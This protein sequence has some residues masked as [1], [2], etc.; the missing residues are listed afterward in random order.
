M[1]KKGK[2]D[3]KISNVHHK[4]TLTMTLVINGGKTSNRNVC[5]GSP[6]ASLHRKR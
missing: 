3:Q 6:A 1:L 4:P 2:K 5:S